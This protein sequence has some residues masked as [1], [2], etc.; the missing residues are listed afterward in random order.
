MIIIPA[1]GL[2]FLISAIIENLLF[3]IFSSIFS[4]KST[5]VLF[6]LIKS[7]KDSDEIVFLSFSIFSVFFFYYFFKNVIGHFV[8]LV[9]VYKEPQF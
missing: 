8:F 5:K 4:L 6:A 7:F 2:A 3:L 1:D 9:G